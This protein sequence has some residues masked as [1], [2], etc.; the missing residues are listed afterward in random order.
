VYFVNWRKSRFRSSHFA[1]FSV[2]DQNR[3]D[4]SEVSFARETQ[5]V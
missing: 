1:K 2:V 3:S 5:I 4:R